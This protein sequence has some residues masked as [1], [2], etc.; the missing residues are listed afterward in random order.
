VTFLPD[1]TLAIQADCNRAR[2]TYAVEGSTLTLQIG[3]VTRMRCATGSLM[4]RFLGE[5]EYAVAVQRAPDALVLVLTEGA[6]MRFTPAPSVP[7]TPGA[8]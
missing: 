3:G 5:L 6:A 4:D 1:A 7:A 8:A 2:G